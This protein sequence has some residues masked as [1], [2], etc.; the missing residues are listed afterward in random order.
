MGTGTVLSAGHP[1]YASKFVHE[2]LNVH[3]KGATSAY[4]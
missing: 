1:L 3:P 4:R 2:L